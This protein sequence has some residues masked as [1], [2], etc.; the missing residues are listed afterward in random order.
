M[1][2]NSDGS[3]TDKEVHSGIALAAGIANNIATSSAMVFKTYMHTY[4]PQEILMHIIFSV[5]YV[6]RVC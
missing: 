6:L 3:E 2:A 1:V 5:A 4:I